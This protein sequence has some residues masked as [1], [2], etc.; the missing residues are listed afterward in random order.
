MPKL[1]METDAVTN[2]IQQMRTKQEEL[3][4]NNDQMK[5][6][7]DSIIPTSWEG[8]SSVQFMSKL[9][10]LLNNYNTK[11]QRYVDLSAALQKEMTEWQDTAMKLG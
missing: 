10:E 11:A 4:T 6:K 3:K 5:S 8:G 2:L 7:A 1:F 9:E